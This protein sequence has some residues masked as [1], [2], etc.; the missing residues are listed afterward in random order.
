MSITPVGGNGNGGKGLYQIPRRQNKN[1]GTLGQKIQVDTNH[2]AIT[3]KNPQLVIYHYDVA[4]EPD[5]PV[6]YMRPVIAKTAKTHFPNNLFGYDNKKNL[7]SKG[8]LP[9]GVAMNATVTI[10]D[11]ERMRDKEYK[12][13]IKKAQEINFASILQFVN[14]GVDQP[15]IAIQALDVILREP[16]CINP[17]FIRVGRSYFSPPDPNRLIDLG[18][19]LHLW[20]G[21]Y[22]SSRI[23]WRPFLNVDVAHKGFPV[24]RSVIDII[25]DICRGQLPPELSD[26]D[27][28]ALKTRVGGLKVIYEIPNQPNSR[29][30]YKVNK[31]VGSAVQERFKPEQGSAEITIS[32]YFSRSK[33][34]RLQFPR[35]PCF[36]VGSV[37]NNSRIPCE[38]CT[39]QGSQI[40][41]K[42]MNEMQTAAMV[43]AAATGTDIRRQKVM[44]AMRR[45]NFGGSAILKDFGIGVSD[46]MERVN[47][48][49]LPAPTVGYDQNKVIPVAKGVWRADKF[50]KASKVTSWAFVNMVFGR[51]PNWRSLIDNMPYGAGLVGMEFPKN[52]TLVFEDQRE[53]NRNLYNVFSQCKQKQIQVVFV[54]VPNTGDVYSKVKQVAELE[55]GVLT[56]CLREKTLFKLNAAT[57]GNILLKLNAKLNGVNHYV[58][59]LKKP[60]IL[61]KPTI[62][63]GA[64][65]T[66]PSPDESS[67]PS[68]AAVTSSYDPAAFKY[69]MMWN[70][71]DAR[72]EIIEGLQIFVETQLRFFFQ[73]NKRKPEHIIFYRD[74]VSEGQFQ[75]VLG[76]E[77]T[78]IKRAC[79]AI[80]P[81]YNPP[82]TFL[83]VQKRHHTRFFPTKPQEGDGSRNNNVRPGTI[84]D[85]TIT[86]PTDLDFYLVSHASI[87]GTARPTKYYRLWD[88]ANLTDDETEEM[89]YYLCHLFSRCTRSVSYPAPTYYAH[90]AAFRGRVYIKNRNVNLSNLSRENEQVQAK[91]DFLSANPMYFV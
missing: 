81:N 78:A 13:E 90:L 58:K 39:L 20:P 31:I 83:V 60:K 68:V 62:I 59:E 26:Y 75:Q 11:E 35:Y 54:A 17:N 53:N 47:A 77:L 74:G 69:N 19:G 44:D 66:H 7:F 30:I 48:R 86:H 34:Y 61:G 65:V 24:T 41:N 88:E 71:Q 85:T 9:F 15:Q 63:F 3:F 33:N 79:Q 29:K 45:I 18:D 5:T 49:I 42:K 55:V 4:I 27:K 57:T 82:V 2:F 16:A 22:Q 50:V 76:A 46:Q 70:M 67:I 28:A 25:K 37:A 12:V 6:R 91:Q 14:S 87:Q 40:V 36:Q 89:T 80:E 23:G 1:G 43:K 51:P 64:D 73:A 84:V 32:D 52:P 10:F 38:L 56:Q 21:F 72:V 8:P